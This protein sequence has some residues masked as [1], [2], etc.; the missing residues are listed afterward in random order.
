MTIT[1]L[2][3]RLMNLDPTLIIHNEGEWNNTISSYSAFNSGGVEI[4]VG[5]FLYA[6]LRMI[7]PTQVLE[8]GT[9]YAIGASYMGMALKDNIGGHLDTI[10]FIEPIYKAAVERIKKM[11]LELY[12]TCHFA[13]AGAFDPKQAQYEIIFLDTEPGTRFAE[14]LKFYPYLAEGGYLFIHDLGRHLQQIPIPNLDFAWPF[15]K[16]PDEMVHLMKEGK[17]RPFH[18][19]TPRG[20]SGFYKVHT[21]DYAI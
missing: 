2:T 21:N 9:H 12:V 4:E 6:F 10:E 18:F 16:L 15:G 17:V 19:S 20:L 11:G 3:L 14:F 1:E 5:E 8:T 13:D 7:K